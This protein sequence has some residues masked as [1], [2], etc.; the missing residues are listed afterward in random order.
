MPDDEPLET[1]WYVAAV[2]F[3]LAAPV[4][5]VSHFYYPPC[6]QEDGTDANEDEDETEEVEAVENADFIPDDPL[7][8]LNDFDMAMP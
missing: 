3:T 5:L 4:C 1:A 2:L 6:E 8:D 7:G